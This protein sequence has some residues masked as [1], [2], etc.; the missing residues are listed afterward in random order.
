MWLRAKIG[1]RAGVASAKAQAEMKARRQSRCRPQRTYECLHSTCT[2]DMK[3]RVDL[4]AS[5]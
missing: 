2:G 4:D 3:G 5:T 1:S